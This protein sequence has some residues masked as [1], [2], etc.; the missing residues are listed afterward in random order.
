MGG[1]SGEAD[2]GAE[3]P[4]QKA[5]KARFVGQ[6]GEG[7]EQKGGDGSVVG[8]CLSQVMEEKRAGWYLPSPGAPQLPQSL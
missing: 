1:R 6:R 7:G 8:P 5:L 2:R 3:W 4:E